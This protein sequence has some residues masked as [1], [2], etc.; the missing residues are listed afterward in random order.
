MQICTNIILIIKIYRSRKIDKINSSRSSCSIPAGSFTHLMGWSDFSLETKTLVSQQIEPC[1]R[2]NSTHS[3]SFISIEFR[4]IKL[5][6]RRDFKGSSTKSLSPHPWK[7]EIQYKKY[8]IL[9]LKFA[10]ATDHKYSHYTYTQ[11]ITL[12]GDGYVS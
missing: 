6:A 5:R 1:K 9:Y 2:R 11:M 4:Y 3:D 10:K 8:H 7:I 12:R